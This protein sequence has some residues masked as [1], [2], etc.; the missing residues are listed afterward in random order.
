L[1]SSLKVAVLNAGALVERLAQDGRL[2]RLYIDGEWVR[3]AGQ[4]RGAVID[5]STEAPI[6]D[7]A[8]GNAQDVA[9]AVAAAGGP[10]RPGP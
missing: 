9:A 6:A 3:P 5:P 10:S 4:G 2:D 8:W 1:E 7:I